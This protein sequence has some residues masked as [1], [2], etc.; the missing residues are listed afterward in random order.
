MKFIFTLGLILSS[1]ALAFGQNEQSPLVEK[2]IAYKDWVYKNIQTDKDVNLR[3]FTAGK[4]LVMVVYFAPWC[5]NWKHDLPLVQ[6]LYDKYRSAGFDVIAVGEYEPVDSMKKLLEP[7]KPT[8]PVVWESDARTAKQTTSHYEYR[9]STGDTRNW[10]SPWYIFLEGG[11]LEPEGPLMTKHT[12]VVNGE[13]I[14]P[15]V[16]KYIREKLGLPALAATDTK[17][18]S[19]AATEVCDPAKPSTALVKPAEKP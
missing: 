8:F 17:L 15:E 5:P 2:D 16:E 14:Q 19:Q 12:R 11:K 3:K 18:S 1:F 7:F 6:S 4:K 9:H 10:G 13:I